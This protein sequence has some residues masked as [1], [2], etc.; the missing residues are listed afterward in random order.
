VGR[1][2]A[3]APDAWNDARTIVTRRW[4]LLLLV[5]LLAAIHAFGQHA[6]GRFDVVYFLL[7]LGQLVAAIALSAYIFADTM[8][9]DDPSYELTFGRALILVLIGLGVAL[10]TVVVALPGLALQ[11]YG[12]SIA[13]IWILLAEVVVT[14]KL[15][16]VFFAAENEEGAFR[17]SWRITSGSAFLPTLVL[18]A[19]YGIG[20]GVLDAVVSIALIGIPFGVVIVATV[21][22]LI[23]FAP[24]MFFSPWM[25]RWM[26]VAETMQTIVP[27]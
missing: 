8:R 20:V 17:Y 2:F 4:W 5:A 25:I 13:Q 15:G 19:I 7:N 27:A 1:L 23:N 12:I 16:Y 10:I 26:R 3:L 11:A 14:T 21:S 9:I 22:V 6:S 24:A 18:A